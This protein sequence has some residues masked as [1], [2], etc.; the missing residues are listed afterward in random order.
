MK[1]DTRS[2]P[3][4]EEPCQADASRE[5]EAARAGRL[6][7]IIETSFNEIYIFGGENLRFE[8][9][10]A[11]AVTNTGYS[12]EEL[13]SMNPLDLKPAFTLESFALLLLPLLEGSATHVRLETVHCRKDGSTYD[14][15][16]QVQLLG[17]RGDHRFAA[18]IRDVTEKNCAV[19]A[20]AESESRFK[21][22]FE[23]NHSVMLLIDPD[24]GRI[25]DCN[26]AA[27]GFY[28]YPRERL[29]GMPIIEVNTLSPAEVKK[30]MKRAE[31]GK[32]SYFLFRHRLADGSLRDVEVYSGVIPLEGK[33]LLYSIIHDVTE[34]VIAE[35][36][37]AEKTALLDQL[38]ENAPFAI[39]ES[40]IGGEILRVN[41]AARELFGYSA[42]EMIGR[43]CDD[44]VVP[45]RLKEEGR[46]YTEQLHGAR[47]LVAFED[48]RQRKD[49]SLMDVSFIGF[50]T[51]LEGTVIGGYGIYHDMTARKEAERLLQESYLELQN[52]VLA[53]RRSWNQTIHIL[54]SVVEARDPYTAGHQKKVA[55]LAGE[56]A[57]QMGLP[58]DEIDH[59]ILAALIHDIGKIEVPSEILSKPGILSSLEIQLIRTHPEA[60]RR[61]LSGLQTPWPL[62]EIVFQHHERLDGSGYPRG[63][64]GDEILLAARIIAVAD[65]VEAMSSHRPYRPAWPMEAVVAEMTRLRGVAFDAAVVDAW[66]EI[67][68]Q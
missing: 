28:G 3:L 6:S 42:E 39:F 62:A 37:L 30:E 4:C 54:A 19:L 50:P 35:K 21:S 25:V 23:K 18:I 57:S 59:V 52:Q 36:A 20:L 29:C 31:K 44:L 63:I 65:V 26:E 45:D 51:R 53:L 43:T 58:D 34:R 64:S 68:E 67:R 15:E 55:L 13:C 16:V 5:W 60:G 33:S 56:I 14:V 9:A 41:R 10:N 24:G 49:G 47:Q 17:D 2:R 12:L 48:V 38:F 66:L 8:Y 46:F 7:R 22:L 40:R 11:A 27:V 61:V 1:P 32:R